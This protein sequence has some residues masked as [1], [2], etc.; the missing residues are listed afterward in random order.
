MLGGSRLVV[1]KGTKNNKIRSPQLQIWSARELDDELSSA[2]VV[3]LRF[4][5]RSAFLARG[6]CGGMNEIIDYKEGVVGC[7]EIIGYINI[8]Y[9]DL[10]KLKLL[11]HRLFNK[12]IILRIRPI[13]NSRT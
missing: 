13:K 9:N 2:A 7:L 5:R 12:S 8:L 4:R 10:S 3:R 11:S 6:T 1:E